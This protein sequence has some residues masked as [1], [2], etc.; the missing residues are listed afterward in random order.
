MGVSQRTT[1][2]PETVRLLLHRTNAGPSPARHGG[3]TGF[4]YWY[5]CIIRL[6]QYIRIKSWEKKRDEAVTADLARQPAT[7][8]PRHT[9]EP[10]NGV[11]LG[12]LKARP[13]R[14]PQDT[15]QSGQ[16]RWQPQATQTTSCMSPGMS[17]LHW[18]LEMYIS[19]FLIAVTDAAVDNGA[20]SW[21]HIEGIWFDG[22]NK[23]IGPIH[24]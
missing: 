16:P 11:Y 18:T 7:N 14:L 8:L 19:L 15:V 24:W 6:F 2:E 3:S 13:S 23:L 1:T 21:I 4:V 17:T 10:P 22:L 12:E 20:L 5:E 9:L